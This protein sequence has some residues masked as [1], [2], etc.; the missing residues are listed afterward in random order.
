MTDT[1][2]NVPIQPARRSLMDRLSIVWLIP[3]AALVIALG[4]A[5]QSYTDRGPL[6]EIAF[7]NASGVV[8]GQT[9]V[10]YRDVAVGLVET[11]GFTENLSQVLVSVRLDNAVA[12]Y[13]DESAEFYV[14]RPEIS[15]RGIS[16]LETV[17]SG[18][19]I[20]AIWDDEA[21]GLQSRHE[22]SANAPIFAG[23]PDGLQISLK[24]TPEAGL[25]ENAPIVYQGIEVGRI[26]RATITPDGL[27]V[28]AEAIVYAPHRHL[29]TTSTRF[30]DA[31]GFSFSLGPSGASLD[32][33]SVASLVSGGVTF[34]TVV[35]GGEPAQ[36]GQEFLVY[37]DE[38]AARSSV[39]AEEEGV[40]LDLTAIFDDNVSGLAVDAPI[41]LG[42]VRIGRV[43]ALN[44]M[45]DPLRFGDNRVRL[46]ATLSINPSR[47]GLDGDPTP[48][49]ALNFLSDR[50]DE[51]MRARLVTASILSGGL[52][53]ELITE[54]DPIDPF[55]TLDYSAEPNPRFP[56]TESDIADVSATA[57]GVF[58]RINNLPIEELLDSAINMLDNISRVA[59]NPDLRALPGDLRGAVG[60]VRGVIGS[61]A[62]QGLPD[63]ITQVAD[64]IETLFGNLN[65]QDVSGRIISLI[66]TTEEAAQGVTDSVAGV[67][68][69][70]ERLNAIAAKAETVPLDQLSVD[71]S[72]LMQAATAVLDTP[73]A[74]ELPEDLGNA[75][76]ELTAVLTEFRE[77]GVVANVNATFSSA[78]EAADTLRD[79]ASQLPALLSQARATM[80]RASETIEGYDAERGVGR[81]LTTAL[82]EVERAAAAVNSL[83]RALE[84]NPNS[85]LFGR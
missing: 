38:G 50:V 61:E 25:T 70:V 12:D 58:E 69:L 36:N 78:R 22:G 29:V 64:Q 45:V 5:W 72:E 49:T 17:L 28:E 47:L 9:E 77:G 41:D 63:R 37:V 20:N 71:L 3:L 18:V 85:L 39:F 21:N 54:D 68:D 1:P 82:R 55:A 8:A 26:G 15:A 46:A 10:R 83:A 74:R 35:S 53:I 44:G 59:A 27:T 56:T 7:D 51:G 80:F 13:V 67:P 11:I 81:D 16:G 34:R 75:L 32:F 76:T 14:V 6:V 48:E 33:S 31:S 23:H 52:K 40:T 43:T 4:V 84:R 73:G 2:P 79:V 42:G 24:A 19:Y 57:E 66:E 60:D 62:I 65:E 30:W